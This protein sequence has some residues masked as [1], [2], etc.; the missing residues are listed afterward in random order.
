MTDSA[1]TALTRA[2]DAVWEIR[3]GAEDGGGG[4]AWAARSTGNSLASGFG[5]LKAGE[6]PA[7]TLDYDEVIHV[8]DGTLGVTCDGRQ[9]VA[10]AGDVLSLSCGSIVSYSG[11]DAEFFFVVTAT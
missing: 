6:T 7:K 1:T 9:L 5:R 11:R 10:R 4:I 3:S 8:L 2:E